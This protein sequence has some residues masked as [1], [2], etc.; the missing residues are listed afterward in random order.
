[1]NED[2]FSDLIRRYNDGKATNDEKALIEKWLAHRSAENLFGNLSEHDKT[3]IGKDIF[4]ALT[5]RIQKEHKFG[6]SLSFQNTIAKVR[7]VKVYKMAAAILVLM[8]ASYFLWKHS[9]IEQFKQVE[10]LEA[11]ASGEIK[12]V[13]LADGSIVWLKGKSKLIYP[14]SFRGKERHVSL[15]GEAL[16]EVAKDSLHPFVITTGNLITKVLGTS[17]NIKAT[18]KNIEVVVLTGKVALSSGD[19]KHRLIVTANEKALFSRMDSRLSKVGALKEEPVQAVL[20]TEYSMSF[21]A[22]HLS[23]IARRIEQKFEVEVSLE[24]EE[25]NTCMITADFTDQSLDRTLG[26]IS[27]VLGFTYRIEGKK[28]TLRG[29][30]CK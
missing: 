24:N 12:K 21:N 27:Q 8:T 25:M 23:E 7:Q 20:K 22:A 18:E 17:F 2:V 10:M 6:R 16:F 3:E 1:M 29:S 9:H 14:P 13:M 4:L 5:A 26:M 19:E 30:G 11:S 15:A 28:V